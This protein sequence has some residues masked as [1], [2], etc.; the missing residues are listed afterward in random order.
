MKNEMDNKVILGCWNFSNDYWN[1]FDTHNAYELIKAALKFG[2]TEFDTAIA[3]GNGKSEQLLSDQLR[4]LKKDNPLLF[5]TSTKIQIASK[6]FLKSNR[7]IVD[8]LQLSLDRMKLDSLDT[9][10]IHWPLFGTSPAPAIDA[11]NE[12]KA[13]GLIQKIGISNF[14]PELI[15]EGLKGGPI[16]CLQLCY[17]LLWTFPEDE[18][19]PLADSHNIETLFYSPLAQGILSGKFPLKQNPAQIGNRQFLTLFHP[20]LW[21]ELHP[22]IEE[23][24]TA[25]GSH[26]LVGLSLAYLLHQFPTSKIVLGA[27]SA[28]QLNATLNSLSAEHNAFANAPELYSLF[29]STAA[30]SKV[31]I[32]K[33][34]PTADNIFNHKW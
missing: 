4:K 19:I 14:T 13:Q 25:S 16:D 26:S 11:L 12:C 20:D 28:N 18:L 7:N 21:K 22:L 24:K 31:A 2:I 17:N 27:S 3:Y 29:Q 15:L 5:P 6:A 8:D 32:R 34:F 10:Y 30:Q 9:Y 33:H 1:G 23:L